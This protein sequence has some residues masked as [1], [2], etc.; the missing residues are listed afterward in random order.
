MTPAEL[1]RRE[2]V[3]A[4]TLARRMG[5]SRGSVYNA[6]SLG[7]PW[8]SA[9]LRDGLAVTVEGVAAALGMT[10]GETFDALRDCVA[11]Y[12]DRAKDAHIALERAR[13]E[14]EASAMGGEQ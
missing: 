13:A 7:V 4:A 11:L 2:G 5:V 14:A 8:A 10:K 6:G 3:E 12:Y 9:V 1:A